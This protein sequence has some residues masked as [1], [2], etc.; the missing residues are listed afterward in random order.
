MVVPQGLD[1]LVKGK[2]IYKW[3]MKWG[4]PHLWNPHMVDGVY[5]YVFLTGVVDNG[6]FFN[7][8]NDLIISRD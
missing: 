5:G 4:N 3:M 7:V 8:D 1:G 6:Y 2:S